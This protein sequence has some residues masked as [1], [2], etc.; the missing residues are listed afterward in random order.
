MAN[1][2]DEYSKVNGRNS[3]YSTNS[4]QV[5]DYNDYFVKS[6]AKAVSEAAKAAVS[7]YGSMYKQL[8]KLHTI[9]LAG[10]IKSEKSA[11][12]EVQK[13]WGGAPDHVDYKNI[14]KQQQE[15]TKRIDKSIADMVTGL[16][17]GA[18]K[19]S[20][21]I[22]ESGEEIG[23]KATGKLKNGLTNVFD[24]FIQELSNTFSSAIR[25]YSQA[26]ESTFS[27]LAGRTG[28]GYKGTR[29]LYSDANAKLYG[30]GLNTTIDM[31][32]ELI[33]Q[34]SV[35]A[36]KGFTGEALTKQALD[37]SLAKYIMPWLDTTSSAF[38]NLSFNLNDYQMKSL[39]SAQLQLQNTEAGNRLLQS[40]VI[41][42]LTQEMSPLLST[43]AINTSET[44]QNEIYSLAEQLMSQPGMTEDQAL[45]A[46]SKL[47]QA[48]LNPYS[49]LMNGSVN[50]KLYSI[51]RTSGKSVY[52]AYNN[53]FGQT[54]ALA[55][56]TSN[57][58]AS[59]AIFSGLGGLYN[60]EYAN[61][62]F[63]TQ[64]VSDTGV[65]KKGT[66]A[67]DKATKNVKE[68]TTATHKA[69]TGINNLF[70]G[71]GE[72]V[73]AIPM[74]I[75]IFEKLLSV[76]KLNIK[77]LPKLANIKTYLG[78]SALANSGAG[79]IFKSASTIRK[80]NKA[81]KVAEAGSAV[82][83]TGMIAGFKTALD[84]SKL[85]AS[86]TKIGGVLKQG[87][88]F[89]AA[90]SSMVRSMGAYSAAAE[91]GEAV[92][93]TT[94]LL[95]SITVALNSVTPVG[96][97]VI[98]ASIIAGIGSFIGGEEGKQRVK[99]AL[100]GPIKK[101]LGDIPNI[102][103]DES[104]SLPM[105][106]GMILGE[107]LSVIPK[108]L[109]GWVKAIVTNFK[110][111]ATNKDTRKE[112]ADSIK[113]MF[114][115]TFK[116]AFGGIRDFLIGLLKGTSEMYGDDSKESSDKKSKSKADGSHANGIAYV[117][118]DGY[119]AELHEGERVLT[120]GE[121][122]L[123]AKGA[124]NAYNDISTLNNEKQ[125]TTNN[126]NTQISYNSNDELIQVVK[127]VAS[128]I[129]QSIENVNKRDVTQRAMPTNYDSSIVSLQAGSITGHL[130]SVNLSTSK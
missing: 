22:S 34:M 31:S 52:D 79:K 38:V 30:S 65:I 71:I 87:T 62:T 54:V 59:G 29:A 55:Q 96:W 64:R 53:S 73:T 15:S 40:G 72:I 106:I 37:N 81:S 45:S 90:G 123:Y 76:V 6:S 70:N 94:S 7:E 47:V 56:S 5:D 49:T 103:H 80:A 113:H 99:E 85:G 67:Y 121:A 44:F 48:E 102:V 100:T 32:S 68:Y 83:N 60:S 105:K 124:L 126:N 41:N 104:K 114:V 35:E 128:A 78:E 75:L 74:G 101:L 115:S 8:N 18:E 33:P 39:K 50:E 51:N 127:D 58:Y 13:I 23:E 27:N 119:T 82:A 77:E 130:H 42:T 43:L 98:A 1:F 107:A 25:A 16:A 89:K 61:R 20:E 117:P 125:N 46:A 19:A 108:T 10:V 57:P 26:Y 4:K 122:G 116:S 12:R 17:S 86:L 66:D 24:N 112:V 63:G 3:N 97:A 88:G 21:K 91:G 36:S 95:R 9:Y 2:A 84:G 118:F 28:A 92:K 111:F 109:I 120:K 110:E 93:L 11:Y 129:I 14:Y 69:T